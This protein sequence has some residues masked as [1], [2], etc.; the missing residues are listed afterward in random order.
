[1]STTK[2]LI[3]LE[4]KS[5]ILYEQLKPRILEGKREAC[6]ITFNDF[7]DVRF[8]ISCHGEKTNI[9]TVNMAMRNVAQLKSLGSDAVLARNFPGME[10]APEAGYD[11]AIEFNCDDLPNPEVFLNAISELKRHVAAGPYER[12]FEALLKKQ[13]TS[14]ALAAIKFRQNETVY[15]SSST[16][17]VAVIYLIEFADVT[18]NA[19]AR[20]FL[21]EFVEA[22]R[23]LRQ[24]PPVSFS[25]EPPGELA[26]LN[27]AANFSKYAGFI[28]FSLEDRHIVGAKME[29]AITVLTGFRNYLH[30]HIKCSKTYLHMRMRKRAAGWLQVLNR[31]VPV[32]ETEKKTS[33]GKTFVRK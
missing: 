11:V 3:F 26:S 18:D 22:Q 32:V 4:A 15:I 33:G 2:G 27:I 17:K 5:A 8:K 30:Y 14:P 12:A 6:E 16:E 21:Q 19:I 20:V 24:A 31:S 10:I 25:R 9:V 13:A 7:D 29:T 23:T 28:S 1:M